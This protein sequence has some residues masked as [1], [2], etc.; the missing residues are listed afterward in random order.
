MVSWETFGQG[1][2]PGFFICDGGG[3]GLAWLSLVTIMRRA[4]EVC[5]WGG[6]GCR[7]LCTEGVGYFVDI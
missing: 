5:V 3:Y 2:E 7:K 1:E 6:E 4:G